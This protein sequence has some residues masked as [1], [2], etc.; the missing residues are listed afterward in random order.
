MGTDL[1]LA[2]PGTMTPVE[3]KEMYDLLLA[4]VE[5]LDDAKLA[6]LEAL[7]L[8]LDTDKVTAFPKAEIVHQGTP[9]IS[10]GGELLRELEAVA[11]AHEPRRGLF[12][13]DQKAPVCSS[14]DGHVPVN[15]PQNVEF[16]DGSGWARTGPTCA[17][18]PMNVWGSAAAWKGQDDNASKACTEKRLLGLLIKGRDIPVL[19]FVPPTSLRAWAQHTADMRLRKAALAG[20]YTRIRVEKE[21]AGERTWGGLRFAPGDPVNVED[22]RTV[23]ALK[24]ALMGTLEQTDIQVDQEGV[25]AVDEHGRPVEA[26]Y[27]EPAEDVPPA[28]EP[29]PES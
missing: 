1:A 18:C 24:R 6:M 28:E 4:D 10:V 3:R 8:A 13:S 27:H 25:A 26:E 29:P 9:G 21:E 17:Q 16:G 15:G 20:H 12:S 23:F 19:L 11:L 7:E 5:N 2:D 14:L 22:R